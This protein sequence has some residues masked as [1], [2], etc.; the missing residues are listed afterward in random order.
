MSARA[1]TTDSHAYHKRDCS[2]VGCDRAS[3]ARGL[4]KG[5]HKRMMKFGD[6]GQPFMPIPPRE[7]RFWSRVCKAGTIPHE[8]PELGPCWEWQGHVLP[9]GYGSLVLAGKNNRAHRLAYEFVKGE[10]PAGLDLDH[11]CRN[12]TCVN[13][14][15]LE[16]VTRRENFLRGMSPA[17]IVLRTNRCIRG[18]LLS[19]DNVYVNPNPPNRRFCRACRRERDQKVAT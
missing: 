1:W 11:L 2:V 6:P 14:D 8:R 15:H 12:R 4:C 18:H 19:P 5:H 16:P 13:P 17:A 3:C 9:T 7:E 10:I